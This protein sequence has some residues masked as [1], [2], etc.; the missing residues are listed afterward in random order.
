MEFIY[1]AKYLNG[2]RYFRG[3]IL[4]LSYFFPLKCD[5]KIFASQLWVLLTFKAKTSPKISYSKFKKGNSTKYG[6]IYVF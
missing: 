3:L 1:H 2:P 6:E 5:L 4:L